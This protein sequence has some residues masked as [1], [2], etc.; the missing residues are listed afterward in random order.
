MTKTRFYISILMAVLFVALAA[1]AIP[2]PLAGQSPLNPPEGDLIENQVDADVDEKEAL[3]NKVVAQD[4]PLNPPEG[5]LADDQS[6]DEPLAEDEPEPEPT[7]FQMFWAWVQQ[8][9]AEA[10]LALLGILKIITN[11]TPTDKDNKWYEI[12]ENFFNAIF[13]NLKKGGGTHSNATT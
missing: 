5:D 11:L 1:I 4:S 10:V 7:A 12:I 9:A 13:P 6:E 8:N 2:T 3:T